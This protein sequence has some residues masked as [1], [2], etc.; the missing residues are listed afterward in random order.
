MN[1]QGLEPQTIDEHIRAI[2]LS[3]KQLKAKVDTLGN[4]V[5]TLT[6]WKNEID[7]KFSRQAGIVV[8]ASILGGSGFIV[9]LVTAIISWF[10]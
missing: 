10:R 6:E 4:K 8:G 9:A 3:L 2:Y 1:Q 5:D 7:N